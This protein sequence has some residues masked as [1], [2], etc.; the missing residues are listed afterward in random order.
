MYLV[1]IFSSLRI[2]TP[3]F[4][5]GPFPE[6]VD[7]GKSTPR[8]PWQQEGPRLHRDTRLHVELLRPLTGVC[9]L[10]EPNVCSAAFQISYLVERSMGKS[11][12]HLDFLFLEAQ[13]IFLKALS[14]GLNGRINTQR[15]QTRRNKEN[16]DETE[17]LVCSPKT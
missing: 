7:L 12:D 13:I 9:W 10:Y 11:R 6:E 16:I 2:Q 14:Y 4:T 3:E 17:D 8:S 15:R 1:L 5:Q